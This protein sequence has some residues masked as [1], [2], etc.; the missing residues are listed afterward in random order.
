MSNPVPSSQRP[1]STALGT[2]SRTRYFV[3]VFA[4]ILAIIQYIDRVAIS[5]AAPLI[6]RDLSLNKEQMAMVF[7]AFTLAYALFEIPTGYMGDR[8]GAKRVLIRVVLWWSFFT[9]A[10]GWVWNWVSLLIVRFLFGAGEAGCFPNIARAFNRWLP[11]DERVR[12]QGILWMFARWGGAIAPLL[13]VLVLQYVNWRRAFEVFA[14]LG[15]IWCVFWYRW[16]H[17]RPGDHPKVNDAEL[18]LM[19]TVE[20]KLEHPKMPWGVMVSSPSLW[21]LWLQYFTLSYAWYFFVTWFPTYLLEVHKYDL[22][23][24]GAILAGLPLFFGGFGSLFAGYITP[25]IVRMTGS[26]RTTRSI[27]G[28]AGQGLAGVC[29]IS[30]TFFQQPILAVLS[31]A[32]ASFF[33]D[34]TMPGSWTTCMD[35]GGRFTGTVSGAMNM[36]GNFG[37]VVSPLVL[38]AIVQRTG[39]WN[40]TF[41][42]TGALYFVGA[43]CWLFINSTKPLPQ[44][45]EH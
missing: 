27:L 9:A 22:K 21:L 31:I 40:L 45:L 14:V 1:A 16:F 29:L 12:A 2:P 35:I 20:G 25:A 17:D 7:S 36:M 41:Y 11:A 13:L 34:I 24:Q 44:D 30:A 6:S 43:T 18:A 4:V 28:F 39:D 37:G 19:P 32:M 15:V 42:L 38:G 33:N 23:V 10:T 5:Q 3:V 26:V 8:L